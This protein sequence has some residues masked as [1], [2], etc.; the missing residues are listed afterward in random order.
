MVNEEYTKIIDKLN[1]V[2][3]NFTSR[4]HRFRKKILSK[5]KCFSKLR[6]FQIAL[7]VL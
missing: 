6:E 3:G 4:Q 1:W 7:S 5:G 2:N